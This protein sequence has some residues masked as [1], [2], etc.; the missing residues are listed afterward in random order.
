MDTKMAACA[1]VRKPAVSSEA[2]RAY[3]HYAYLP[4]RNADPTRL[5]QGSYLLKSESSCAT[6]CDFAASVKQG[7]RILKRTL[8]GAI[9]AHSGDPL[10]VLPL[11]GGLDSRVLLGGLL[12]NLDSSQ[13]L[14]VTFGTPGTLDFDIGRLV[15]RACSV[16]S[17]AV[18][19]TSEDWSWSMSGLQQCA[20][21]CTRPGWVFDRYV[22][23]EILTRTGPLAAYWSGFGAPLT[24][25]HCSGAGPDT[26][27]EAVSSFA[28]IERFAK[29]VS[30][31]P[32]EYDPTADLPS[33][34]LVDRSVLRYDEQLFFATRMWD[35]TRYS[36]MP[37]GYRWC[38]PFLDAQMVDFMFSCPP[39]WRA[40]RMLYKEIVQEAY[41]RLSSLPTKTNSGL[42]LGAPNWRVRSRR[43]TRRTREALVRRTGLARRF[44]PQGTNYVDWDEALRNRSDLKS[45][46]LGCLD[47]LNERGVASDI[48]IPLETMWTDHQL[49]RKDLW[50]EL[51]LLASLGI[52]LQ[53]GHWDPL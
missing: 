31:T 44:P 35:C 5:P 37:D 1:D 30:L 48:G 28:E 39:A 40:D 49:R 25:G 47:G 20:A 34:P 19:L 45:V 38:A 41:P 10:H 53:C 46:V 7:A 32:P 4:D 21:A 17:E 36:N 11:S 3:L 33:Q 23:G 8:A 6:Q 16:R 15:A 43:A 50:R 24:G 26:W 12:E 42:P 29:S 9:A 13:I 27:A 51:L 18:D 52:D 2:I 14:A 22:M